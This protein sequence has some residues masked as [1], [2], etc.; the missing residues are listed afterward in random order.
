VGK[1]KVLLALG[2]VGA[3]LLALCGLGLVGLHFAARAFSAE[4][5]WERA[6]AAPAWEPR[7]L[8]VKI[9]SAARGFL[10]RE[11]GFQDP[12]DELVFE[13]DPTEVP[14]FLEENHLERGQPTTP[15]VDDVPGLEPPPTVT[16]L[17]GL[18]DEDSDAGYVLVFRR[19][20]LW[21]WP[22]RAVIYLGAFST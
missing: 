18:E 11:R 19:A 6:T 17:N 16:E 22:G 10:E 15:E 9:P 5:Q 8:R 3:T 20:Q 1:R 2:L 21:E 4:P 12:I 13:L 14:R 7:L